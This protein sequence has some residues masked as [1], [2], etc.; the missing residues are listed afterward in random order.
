MVF[1][2]EG[3][4]YSDRGFDV[5]LTGP[6]P[7]KI[8]EGFHNANCPMEAGV[9]ARKVV[10]E[11]NAGD[12]GGILG[13]TEECSDDG[14][15]ATRFVDEGCSNPVGFFL[16]KVA[17]SFGTAGSVEARNDGASGF[18]AGVGI[19]YFHINEE[20]CLE[21]AY[22]I[23]LPSQLLHQFRKR[24]CWSWRNFFWAGLN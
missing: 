20:G 19:Y 2:E 11:D 21:R 1:S 22:L 3:C 23:Y 12:A 9:E 5:V 14:I 18:A 4:D 6:D 7:S 24:A 16:E 8:S 10:E 15:E 13:F 17:G